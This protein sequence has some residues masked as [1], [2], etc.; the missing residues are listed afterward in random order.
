MSASSV[1]PPAYELSREQNELVAVV[2]AAIV[3]E[4][5]SR[6]L[7]PCWRFTHTFR[8]CVVGHCDKHR[9]AELAEA[10][11]RLIYPRAANPWRTALPN[12]ELDLKAEFMAHWDI[13]KF[14]SG[15]LDRAILLSEQEY[16]RPAG[17]SS[18]GY[19]SFLTVCQ[20]LQRLSGKEPFFIA[21]EE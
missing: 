4:Y 14:P 7:S 9:A 21:V 8:S 17:A 18:E 19:C 11:L 6:G 15:V 16:F 10:G 12:T 20:S 13:I 3:S 1:A 2:Q 5:E